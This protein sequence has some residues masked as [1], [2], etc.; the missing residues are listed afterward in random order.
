MPLTRL[1]VL[2]IGR[3][4][5]VA[6]GVSFLAFALL[7]FAPGDSA[8][9]IAI[10]RYGSFGF[11]DEMVQSIRIEQGLDAP[12]PVRYV[13]WAAGLARGDFGQSVVR[14]A[15]ISA[16]LWSR[17]VSTISLAFASMLLSLAIA[18]PLGLIMGSKPRSRVA[19]FLDVLCAMSAALPVFWL[20][21]VLI[22][23]FAVMFSLLPATG[24]AEAS[25][26]VLPTLSIALIQ[27]PWTAS[28][29]RSA[30]IET[31]RFAHVQAARARGVP[32]WDVLMRHRLLPAITPVIALLGVQF[33][34]LLEGAVI[35]E[36]LFARPG[37]GRLAVDA[38]VARDF[39]VVLACVV[40][41]SA[42]TVAV[43]TFADILQSWLDPR[44][45]AS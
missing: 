24:D 2:R 42:T 25:S 14:L 23:I 1:I 28:L 29:L 31:S 6:L 9:M 13:R 43:S 26:L 12:F 45:R 8:E 22:L 21:N 18:L 38:I 10:A 35:V 16:D 37:L 17:S 39:P 34:T 5:A 36:T 30:L 27:T 32:S 3:A 33:A 40:V 20:G 41:I 4:L 44:V 19:K 11:T 15:P 7:E